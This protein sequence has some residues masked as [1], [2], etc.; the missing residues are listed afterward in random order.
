[1]NFLKY[2][3][4]FLFTSIVLSSCATEYK[5]TIETPKKS[6]LEQT[7]TVKLK[8]VNQKP[9]ENAL[10]YINGK[11]VSST[12]LETIINTNEYGV[13]RHQVSAMVYYDNGKSKRVNNS[14][15]IFATK[16]PV[17]YSF[18]K[19]NSYPHDAKAYT[20]GL[21]Y[22]NGFLYETTGKNGLSSLRKVD[23]K[24]GKVLQQI[25]LD[26]QYFGEGLTILNDK[27]YFLTWKSYKGF[28]YN[29]ETFQLEKEFAYN[30][31]NEGWGLTHNNTELIKS[32]GTHKIWFLDPETLKEKRYI[33]AYTNDRSVKDLNELELINGKLYANKWQKNSIVIIDPNTGVV[34]GVADLELLKKEVEKT[35]KLDPSDDVL[36]GIAYDSEKNRLFVTGKNWNTLFEIELVKNK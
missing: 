25:N 33:Q 16:P 35:Q 14:F 22:Y 26:K 31:S 3:F 12:N 9:I 19:I 20:Q 2:L 23:L 28:V 13:G 15:E 1:M 29:L 36:N 30:K 6:T 32:D 21:E 24:T 18:K 10:F 8:E 11:E 7:F 34:E 4:V 17:V 27:I 5:F